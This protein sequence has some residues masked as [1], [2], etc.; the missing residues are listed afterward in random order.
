MPMSENLKRVVVS[1][2]G[3]PVILI[4]AYL[5]GY[6]FLSFVVVI[7]LMSFYEFSFL[8]NHKGAN[9]NLLLGGIV[10]F[11]FLLNQFL[12][13]V[14]PVAII[15]LSSLSLLTV[16]LFRNKGSAI[17]NL[18]STFLGIFYIGIFLLHLFHFVSFIQ[19]TLL[20]N[21]VLILSFQS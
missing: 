16:E 13:L 20:K 4:S 15:I 3:V 2:A 17:F 5:G 9:V 21:L 18:G 7:S 19:M 8:V 12:D 6:Y 14:D 11:V 10:I 1:I